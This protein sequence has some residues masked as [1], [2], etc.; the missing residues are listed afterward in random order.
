[1]IHFSSTQEQSAH[2]YQYQ[3][4]YQNKFS[5]NTSYI[6]TSIFI[7]GYKS[8]IK[9]LEQSILKKEKVVFI[10]RIFFIKFVHC[11]RP[12]L[13]ADVEDFTTIIVINE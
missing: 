5:M 6:T 13:G 4:V 10:G 11:C 1:M 8:G 3:Y 2:T 12:V 9:L 7:T